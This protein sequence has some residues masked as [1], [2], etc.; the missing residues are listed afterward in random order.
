MYSA[1]TSTCVSTASP[2]KK[3]LKTNAT[4]SSSALNFRDGGDSSRKSRRGGS[5]WAGTP[6]TSNSSSRVESPT[7]RSIQKKR[8]FE[9]RSAIRVRSRP[10]TISLIAREAR[11]GGRRQ[12]QTHAPMIEGDSE[13]VRR[14]GQL[15]LFVQSSSPAT[16]AR[17]P[18]PSR[19]TT[20]SPHTCRRSRLH[21]LL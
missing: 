14:G 1:V 15:S 10:T 3:A 4:W 8:L 5:M 2:W 19:G 9:R 21:L 11:R 13:I 6:S 12:R 18:F 20:A 16:R 7:V 17:S